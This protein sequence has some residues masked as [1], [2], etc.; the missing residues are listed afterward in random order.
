M[1]RKITL[2][3][4]L[5]LFA[6]GLLASGCGDSNSGRIVARVGGK[7]IT[8]TELR[9][10]LAELPPFTRQQFAG[11][12]GM[13]EFLD[14]VIEEEVL[15]QAAQ[16][17]GYESTAEV[18]DMVEAVTRRAMIQAYYRDEIEGVVLVPESDIVAYYEEHPEQFRQRA[19]IKFRHIMN[20]TRQ[21]AVA[22]RERVL[23]GEDFASVARDA[24]EDKATSDAGGL[25]RTLNKGDAL[26]TS[27]MSAIFVES[28]FDGAVGEISQPLRSD[29]GWHIVRIEELRPEGVKPLEDVRDIIEQSLKP[30][31]TR[32]YYAEQLEMLRGQLNTTVN[33]DVLRP[34]T[35]TEEELFSLAQETD[36]PV[37]R[38]GYYTELV[39]SYPEGEH[40]DE[41][42]FMI[43]FIQ[44][45]ELK[46]YDAARNALTRMLE[47]Y[48]NSEL[49]E[50][51]RWMLENMGSEAPPFEESDILTGK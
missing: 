34:Q 14:R 5:G 19:Q 43:G 39:F 33:E 28:L 3:C 25:V 44:A 12:E 42:Q 36:D 17:A 9:G 20:G 50:S 32:E 48:P 37:Q 46:N 21:G 11:P 38:M 26:M 15:F 40:A 4:A 22:A 47:H 8:E 45:E 29:R 2:L 7:N 23:A 51:A 6:L 1:I 31:I 10:K 27:G 18:R 49:A 16:R 35:R 13:R 24:S 41:A 30:A